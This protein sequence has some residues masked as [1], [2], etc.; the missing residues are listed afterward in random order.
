MLV[1]T[2]RTQTEIDAVIDACDDFL[3]EG[4]KYP[5]MTYEEGVR[6][7]IDWLL[8]KDAAHPIEEE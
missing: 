3:V 4:S 5:D 6:A 2:V 7:A 8:E 1:P